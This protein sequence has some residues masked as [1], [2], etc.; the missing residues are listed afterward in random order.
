MQRTINRPIISKLMKTTTYRH[1]ADLV[2]TDI[3]NTT[4]SADPAL[5]DLT[6]DASFAEST[7]ASF[8]DQR[9]RSTARNNS[10]SKKHNVADQEEGAGQSKACPVRKFCPH[11]QIENSDCQSAK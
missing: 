11:R 4:N 10:K 6:D 3:G 1:H 7:D 8:A 9:E 5:T 2:R